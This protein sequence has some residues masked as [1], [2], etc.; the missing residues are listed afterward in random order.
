MTE[1][2]QMADFTHNTH[3]SLGVEIEFQILDR[4]TLNLVPLAP[5]L[6]KNSPEILSPRITHEFIRSILEL[7]TSV[8]RTV[9]DV[10]NDLMETCSMA[11]E[12]A[13]DN[14]CLLYAASLHP[15]AKSSEQILTSHERY[16]RIMKELQIVGRQF[17]SQGLHVHI[18]LPDGDTAIRVCNVIQIYL[19]LLLS[20]ST[21][22]PFSHGEDT[23]LLS[24]RTKLFEVL[25]LAGIYEHFSNW[26]HFSDEVEYLKKLGVIGSI[27]D[28]WWD[29]RPSPEY[30]TVEVRIC[31]LPGRFSDILS[32]VALMQ[33][34]I[35][36]IV[37][38]R[39]EYS[40]C[41]QQVLRAN[42][43][44]A[45]RYGIDGKFIDPSAHFGNKMIS[46]RKAIEVL[47]KKVTPYSLALKSENY[48]M[49]VNRI[50]ECGTSAEYQKK[51]YKNTN[52]FETVISQTH[53][54]FWQ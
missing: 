36:Y 14:G 1:Q 47:I 38:E 52:S 26:H 4:D 21:S 16:E 5:V 7:Q 27:S 34:L 40:P 15:F 31:D 33:A 32:L 24:Y 37:E 17:I 9:R 44:Q 35:A 29:A 54:E 50:L 45:V 43:W 11:E 25:P 12:L 20:L 22:S 19:P 8:C 39:M 3:F 46:T 10:E 51:I 18:G 49:L 2:R 53:Q 28:L 41:S 30:G 13:A 42:K 6:L 48:L 23:G